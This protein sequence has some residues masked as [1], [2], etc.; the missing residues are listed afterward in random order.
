[1]M[2]KTSPP[3]IAFCDFGAGLQR[4]WQSVREPNAA[5]VPVTLK[6]WPSLLHP[7]PGVT[8][9]VQASLQRFSESKSPPSLTR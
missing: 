5:P 2:R 1:M 6:H 7:N 8:R 3:D 4:A 9:G